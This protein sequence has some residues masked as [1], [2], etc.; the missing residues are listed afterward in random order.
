MKNLLIDQGKSSFERLIERCPD[1]CTLKKRAA[2]LTAFKEFV[3]AKTKKVAFK[4]PVVNASYLNTA[5]L[6]MVN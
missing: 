4:R 2:Y 6:T 3:I 1:L 5:F